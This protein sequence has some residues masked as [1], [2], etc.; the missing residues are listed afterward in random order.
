MFDVPSDA[1][2]LT[3]TAQNMIDSRN[4]ARVDCT[5]MSVSGDAVLGQ[6]DRAEDVLRPALQAGQAA[7]AG[8]MTGL[9]AGASAMTT[10]YLKER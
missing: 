7:L 10:A 9:A 4:S 3:R 8:E 1:P 5:Y 6:V 2:G